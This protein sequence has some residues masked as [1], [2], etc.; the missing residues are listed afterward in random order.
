MI[1]QERALLERVEV[2][3][4]VGCSE[5]PS[6][7]SNRVARYLIDKGYRVVP[8]NPNHAE[9]LG[10]PTYADLQ[11]VPGAIDLAVIFRR[12]EFVGG[13]VDDAIAAGVPAIWLQLGVG[14]LIEEDR[15]R[16]AGIE[17]ISEACIQVVH[18]ILQIP[19]R[20]NAP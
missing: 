13:V 14:N 16:G 19:A 12:P 2:I 5:R 7:D 1:D 18:H 3:A 9:L 8:V 17:V 6:R 4:V 15:A 11:S 20:H 10:K